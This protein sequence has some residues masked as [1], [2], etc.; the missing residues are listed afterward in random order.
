MAFTM[1]ICLNVYITDIE[2]N[3]KY[4]QLIKL[5]KSIG[6]KV[7]NQ[8][9][10]IL[11]PKDFETTIEQKGMSVYIKFDKKKKVADIH[12]QNF[13]VLPFYHKVKATKQNI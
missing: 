7:Q 5:F 3:V 1:Y 10:Q 13:M 8:R 12:T 2:G 11:I 6:N 4:S 9:F